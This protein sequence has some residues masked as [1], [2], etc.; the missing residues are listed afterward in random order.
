MKTMLVG[1]Y[2]FLHNHGLENYPKL[3]VATIGDTSIFDFH[4]YGRKGS[5]C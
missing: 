3:K 5:N 4:D 1:R 2:P